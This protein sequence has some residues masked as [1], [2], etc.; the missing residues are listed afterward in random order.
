MSRTH[1]F[2]S[3]HRIG[4]RTIGALAAIVA[5]LLSLAVAAAPSQAASVS[6]VAAWDGTT[7]IGSF[8]DPNT[9]TY[10]QVVTVPTGEN[11]LSGFT[12]YAK[13][14]SSLTFRAFVYAWNEAEQRATGPALFEGPD[15][16]ATEPTVFQPIA[17]N[18][19]PVAVS[20]GGQYV[21]FFSTSHDQASDEGSHAIGSYGSL[22]SGATEYE[23]GKFVFENNGYSDV[24]W[25]GSKWS[26]LG[27]SL[28]FSAEFAAAPSISSVSP[29]SGVTAGSQV[30]ISGA[31]FTGATSVLFGSTP[32]T[33]FTVNSD[34]SI[35]ATA[36]KGLAGTLDVR[37]ISAA[38]ESAA[39][40]ADRVTAAVAVPVQIQAVA[41]VVPKMVGMSLAK[42][43]AALAAARCKLGKIQ[44]HYNAIAKGLLSEQDR[45]QGAS[46]PVTSIVNIWLSLGHHHK[47]HRRT[48][49]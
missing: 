5:I 34:T 35:T 1:T 11:R 39:T 44:Y 48:K 29:S 24:T 8:G 41:C 2:A 16:H 15:M 12:F 33:S 9:A 13:L 25:T 40:T 6:T 36:P 38:G 26:T 21:L 37:V 17:V 42:V 27:S 32:A 10:G 3:P 31:G 46:L 30:T 22:Q 19:G 7:S 20:A 18:T 45:H 28:A 4:A 47:H 23:G 14:S 49:H 43:Q